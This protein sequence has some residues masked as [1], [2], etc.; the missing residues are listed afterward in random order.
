MALV[1]RLEPDARAL[2]RDRRDPG[3]RVV[4]MRRMVAAPPAAFVVLD[5]TRAQLPGAFATFL[6]EYFA[7]HPT[8]ATDDRR[9]PLGRRVAGRH[10][11]GSPGA[12]R[13]SSIVGS[14][15]S[16]ASATRPDRRRGHRSRPGRHGAR[17]GA[18]RRDRAARGDLG[19]DGLD[20]PARRRDLHAHRPRFR[21]ARRPAGLG[22]RPSRGTAGRHRWS[23]GGPART[24]RRTTGRAVPDPDGDRAAPRHRRA[25]RRRA[26][27]GGAGRA[28]RI[29][30]WL[31]SG[32]DSRPPARPRR[33]H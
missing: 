1:E 19:R 5:C 8:I 23:Q 31:R 18:L 7:L 10:R 21:P 2:E 29:R 15:S 11:G 17:R 24:R 25:G 22:R 30:R 4:V 12:A 3:Q 28:R 33:R 20:L 9:P 6:D 27:R 13:S 14:G 32:P 16:S 26:G